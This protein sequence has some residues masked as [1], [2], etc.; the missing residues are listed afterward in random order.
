[1]YRERDT[2]WTRHHSSVTV[3][4]GVVVVVVV[5]CQTSCFLI[6]LYDTFG[7]N[8]VQ[9]KLVGDKKKGATR[10]DV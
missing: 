3:V 4:V 1:M 10:I 6:A 9:R 8:L 5:V 2:A 7:E